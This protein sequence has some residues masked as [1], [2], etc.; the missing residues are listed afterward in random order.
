MHCVRSAFY[1]GFS[2]FSGILCREREREVG[3][4][5]AADYLPLTGADRP[6]PN[7]S[8]QQFPSPSI[9]IDRNVDGLTAERRKC[10]GSY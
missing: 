10:H 4:A 9:D 3:I 2:T 7:G 5:G 6:S 8:A 1:Q